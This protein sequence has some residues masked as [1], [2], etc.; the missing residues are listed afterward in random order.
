MAISMLSPAQTAPEGLFASGDGG[1]PHWRV[2]ARRLVS[3]EVRL[4]QDLLHLDNPTLLATGTPDATR[5]RLVVVDQRVGVLFG[6]RLRRYLDA[7]GVTYELCL[8][9]AHE[10]VKTMDSVLKVVA[11]MDAFGVGRR[12][13][14][15]IAVGGG[16]LTDIVGLATSLYRRSTPY[17]RVPTTLIGMVDA[18]IGAKTGVNFHEYKNRLGTYHPAEATL[19]D[20]S[21]LSTLPARHLRN[22]L[23]EILKIALVKDAGLFGLLAEHGPRLV[24]ERMQ[25][26][27]SADGGAV[28]MAVMHGA[29]HCMLQELQP[30][31]WE[32]QLQRVVDYGHSFSPTVEM[33]ALPELLHGEAVCVDMAL[34]IVIARNRGLLSGDEAARVRDVMAALGLPTWHRV[35]SPELL[36][37]ALADTVRHRDGR[38]LMPL[39]AGIGAACFVD[40]VTPAEIERALAE[41]AETG[42]ELDRPAVV[43]A[44]L[45]A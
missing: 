24:T 25:R 1:D 36:V 22:G 33:A 16:V 38:Q 17:V 6:A 39:T 44:Q 45:E 10:R 28:A 12:R 40:D 14:P 11:A 41:L 42:P 26:R 31:L 23:A 27:D 8:V 2:T 20:P 21:F 18:G 7:H 29:I 43:P 35:C 5:R 15:V 9:D 30:N 37:A 3:Y 13:E 34:T 4:C 19:V 32:H